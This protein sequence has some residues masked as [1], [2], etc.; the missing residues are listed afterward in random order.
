MNRFVRIPYAAAGSLARALA[1]VTPSGQS[2]TARALWARRGIGHRYANW[3]AR[4]RDLS[5]PLLWVHAPSV[6]EG[7]QALPVIELFRRRHPQAQLAY[8]FFSPSA[9][10]F[11]AQIGADFCDYLPFDTAREATSALEALQPTSLVFSKLDVWPLLTESAQARGVK[12]ALLSA[13]LPSSSRRHSRAGSLILRDAYRALDA[14]GAVAQDDAARLVQA[15]VRADRVTITGDTR[16]DQAWA[17]AQFDSAEKR[18]LLLPL[19]APRFTVVAGSTWPPD[20][21]RLLPAFQSARAAHPKLRLVIAPHEL[22]ESRRGT[23]EAWANS[24]GLSFARVSGAPPAADGG[25]PSTPAVN[26]DVLI[27]DAYGILGDLYALA[28]IAYVGGGFGNAGLHSL[29]EPAAFG[30]PVLIGPRHTDNRDA[31]QLIAAGGAFR[32]ADREAL[33][34]QMLKLLDDSESLDAASTAA[35]EV[36]RSGLGAA[37]RSVQLLDSLMFGA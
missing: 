4:H 12:L 1:A 35:R 34:N 36:V 27:V 16:Y 13:T 9:E 6:G 17:K 24:S 20:E 37:E 18:R 3:G 5:R 32:C 15:G 25:E 8:T 22:S 10:R 19:R 14:V 11:A 29:L 7:L 2:K 28:D 23:L 33:A 30:A 26:A 21:E 31:E